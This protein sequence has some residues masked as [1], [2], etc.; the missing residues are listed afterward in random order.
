MLASNVKIRI[1]QVQKRR[2]LADLNRLRFPAP[3]LRRNIDRTEN[4]RMRISKIIE[5]AHDFSISGRWLK[6]NRRGEARIPG[7]E[8][9]C[10]YIDYIELLKSPTGTYLVSIL[11]AYENAFNE[12]RLPSE[13]FGLSLGKAKFFIEAVAEFLGENSMDDATKKLRMLHE[14]L[15][16]TTC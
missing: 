13:I 1:A 16:S 8:K 7:L 4:S 6:P 3:I 2:F 11:S 12:E 14:L 9:R 5:E 10:N 15:M